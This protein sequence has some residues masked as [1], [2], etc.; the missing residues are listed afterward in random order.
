MA[1]ARA[2]LGRLTG[3]LRNGFQVADELWRRGAGLARPGEVACRAGCFGCCVGLFEISLPEAILV[4]AGLA[5]LPEEQR[6][7][8]EARARRVVDRTAT[9]FPGDP[10]SG[11]LD[12]ERSEEADDRYF[13]L[14]SDAA[15]P[16]LE[17]PS[18]RCRIYAD[19]PI[20]CRTYGLAW[21]RQEELVHP[22]CPLNF[23][24]DPDR[25]LVTGID[26][27]PLSHGDA[28]LSAAALEAGLP[29]GAET[30]VA[31]AVTGSAF[32]KLKI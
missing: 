4:R 12:P 5:A 25:Q 2:G 20:T 8:V 28:L 3:R 10:R 29:S 17:L 11:V 7:E 19:R 23:V 26:V 21:K 13:D 24:A 31:H 22:A 6:R 18:G 15:C 1:R 30:T 9:A 32:S 16:M 27:E 14:A